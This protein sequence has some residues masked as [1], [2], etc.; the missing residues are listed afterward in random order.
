MAQEQQQP[1]ANAEKPGIVAPP[2]EPEFQDEEIEI[3]AEEGAEAAKPEAKPAEEEPER[4]KKRRGPKR[5]AA[6][7]HERD[8]ARGYALTLEQ[9]LQRERQRATEAE[10]KAEAAAKVSMQTFAAK[11]ETD[12]KQARAEYQAAQESGD[13][14]KITEAAEALASAKQTADDV[15]AYQE[16]EKAKPAP[17]AQ[18]QPQAQPQQRPQVTDY[19]EPVKNWVM[20]EHNRY[21]DQNARDDAGNILV[22]RGG[23]PIKNPDFDEE[24]HIEATMYATKLERQIASGKASF[25]VASPEYFQAI[26]KHMAAEFPDYFGGEEEDAAPPPP[27]P[28][29]SPVASPSRSAT[30]QNGQPSANKVKLSSDQLRFIQKQ[31]D[32][33]GGPKYPKGH[34]KAFQPMT[35]EDAK[36]SFARR[37]QTQAKEQGQ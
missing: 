14:A 5:Y 29:A 28:R 11:A 13:A 9:E 34:P 12:L 23:R 6:L 37:L 8:E 1:S 20:Q 16:T 21:W 35:F 2:E 3:P 17:A 32:N 30:P 4:P 7:A 27:K 15:K 33:G 18:P 22:D 24:M 25:K 31:V 19:P 26:E 36:V 10:A